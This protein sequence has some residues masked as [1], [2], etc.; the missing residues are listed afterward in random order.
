M[1]NEKKSMQNGA[2]YPY[3]RSNT[4]DYNSLLLLI[5]EFRNHK[6]VE[7]VQISEIITGEA[8]DIKYQEK[9]HCIFQQIGEEFSRKPYAIAVQKGSPLKESFSHM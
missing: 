2:F 1:K 6:F 5:V 3:T 4:F 9:T 7:Y 8:T